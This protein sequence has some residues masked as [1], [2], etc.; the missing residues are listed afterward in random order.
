MRTI[1]QGKT[2]GSDTRG[3]GG[4]SA[5]SR[6]VLQRCQARPAGEGTADALAADA[7]RYVQECVYRPRSQGIDSR[8]GLADVQNYRLRSTSNGN[9]TP[10]SAFPQVCLAYTGRAFAVGSG[11]GTEVETSVTAMNQIRNAAAT[12]RDLL[13]R[14]AQL[15]DEDDL[16]RRL[17]VP[18]TLLQAWI[19]GDATIPDAK[20]MDLARVMD[21]RSREGRAR[22]LPS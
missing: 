3:E 7:P 16:A 14:S 5:D 11:T 6:A 18:L 17:K 4:I 20:L 8:E 21:A 1:E 2:S 22:T 10:A 9:R 13:A 15:L 12:K 19:R